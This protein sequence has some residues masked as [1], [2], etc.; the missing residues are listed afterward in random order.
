MI[1][2]SLQKIYCIVFLIIFIIGINC[3]IAIA[4]SSKTQIESDL[5]SV[6]KT[7]C[8]VNAH[9][10]PGFVCINSIV[11]NT[12]FNKST[13][14]SALITCNTKIYRKEVLVAGSGCGWC[15]PIMPIRELCLIHSLLTGKLGRGILV[16]VIISIA[17]TFLSGKIEM[18]QIITLGVAIVCIF[19]SYSIVSLMIG[20]KYQMCEIIN[21]TEMADASPSYLFPD[22]YIATPRT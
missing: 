15:E 9:C 11:S 3:N 17:I 6:N 12:Q 21:S 18:K 20:E 7:L 22:Q 14:A 4:V 19:G 1:I 8:I 13:T 2:Y 5:K 16:L 10:Q